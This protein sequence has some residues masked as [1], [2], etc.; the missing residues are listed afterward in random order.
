M[1][2]IPRWYESYRAAALETDWTRMEERVRAAEFEIHKRQ[3]HV[4]FEGYGGTPQER[5]ALA[6]ALNSLWVLREDL[7]WWQNRQRQNP[8]ENSKANSESPILQRRYGKRTSA[9]A[10]VPMHLSAGGA[11]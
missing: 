2:A 3:Q 8:A 6:S 7:V 5:Y 10:V 4:L 11:D 1:T 9:A